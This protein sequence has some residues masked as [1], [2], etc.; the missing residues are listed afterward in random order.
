M[1]TIKKWRVICCIL[2]VFAM[3]GF[4]FSCDSGE[5]DDVNPNNQDNPQ[6]PSSTGDS[7]ITVEDPDS[8]GESTLPD[9]TKN[10]PFAR[11]SYI[12][13]DGWIA[14]FFNND[15]TCTQK[16]AVGSTNGSHSLHQWQKDLAVSY[17]YIPTTQDLSLKLK[18][19]YYGDTLITSADDAVT[20]ELRATK[21]RAAYAGYTTV[22][23]PE[24]WISAQRK[25]YEDRLANSAITYSC[26]IQN[27][28]LIL[29]DSKANEGKYK[30]EKDNTK[31][32]FEHFTNGQY[33]ISVK[34]NSG[35]LNEPVITSIGNG[36]FTGSDYKW[37]YSGTTA[38][39][40]KLGDFAGTYE[41][42]YGSCYLKLT[43]VTGDISV[44]I[45]DMVGKEY[46]LPPR[47]D[48]ET[49]TT[50]RPITKTINYTVIGGDGRTAIKKAQAYLTD[51]SVTTWEINT[52]KVLTS[53]YLDGIY[54]NAECTRSVI[55]KEILDG[56][57]VYVKL[58]A[59][60]SADTYNAAVGNIS[61]D[62]DAEVVVI[63]G[64]SNLVENPI[65]LEAIESGTITIRNPLTLSIIYVKN[66]KSKAT[67]TSPLFFI[68]V[69]A[70]DKISLYGD[71]EQYAADYGS[72]YTNISCDGDCYLYGNIMS[73]ICSTEAVT[74]FPEE[75]DHGYYRP[76][77]IFRSLFSDNTRIKNHPGKALSLPATKLGS[78]C[79]DHMFSGCTG[80]T[81]A[82]DLPATTL[83]YGC[84]D[85]MFSG[86]TNL[87]SAPVLPATTL[88]YGCYE[89]MFSG[90][91]SLTAAPV[92]PATTLESSC[93][94]FMFS[95][96]T[97]LTAAPVLPA[98][99]LESS[100][101]Y[102]MFSGCSNLLYIKCLA[103]E[104]FSSNTWNWVDS[105][106]YTGIFVTDNPDAWERGSNG[107]PSNWTVVSSDTDT[108]KDGTINAD[109][110]PCI[111]IHA[112]AKTDLIVIYRNGKYTANLMLRTTLAKDT[113]ISFTDL[114]VEKGK[115]YIYEYRAWNTD[116]DSLLYESSPIGLLV[117]TAGE[118]EL[119]LTV[120]VSAGRTTYNSENGVLTIDEQ[121]TI[122]AQL[123]ST[124]WNLE[125]H[126]E[127]IQWFRFTRTFYQTITPDTKSIVLGSDRIDEEYREELK[128]KTADLGWY[129]SV[130]ASRSAE[131]NG[132]AYDIYY[133]S[134]RGYEHYYYGEKYG[135]PNSVVI[136]SGE[137]DTSQ[138]GGS[139]TP[140]LT[141]T[142]EPSN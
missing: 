23:I 54:S 18:G 22:E 53:G 51:A 103:S 26:A 79:Y 62:P 7:T 126:L 80:L 27:D 6:N 121:P 70:G 78:H 110:V 56:V 74:E 66:G 102:N 120:S 76:E 36:T 88:A 75:Y 89:Y 64:N 63:D 139:S 140:V 106:A 49:T 128:G 2:A 25:I 99:T 105:V 65:T 33:S 60:V 100:C 130:I 142:P 37:S 118:G 131:S 137:S 77:Y 96:C 57:Q 17:T 30:Y 44:Y 4:F 47:T 10:A 11:Q 55:G 91:T 20:C 61:D 90:C 117:P 122:T 132:I 13:D 116:E 43:S 38:T 35:E 8:Y 135:L 104:V 28:C 71:N 141:P 46:E 113:D 40:V 83:E 52:L 82:P 45:K 1:E 16:H 111:T 31:I 58:N 81:S 39:L 123:N 41:F 136:P 19:V 32:K 114:N 108:T 127:L 85:S 12:S 109:G 9:L 87:T 67:T 129:V 48:G 50:Y 29:E 95:G 124:G 112:P 94:S 59:N 15:G 73:L 133:D 68:P 115:P 42:E 101:Y 125:K 97:S 93:Y 107:I 14:I 72:K 86:C 21:R 5:N 119:K 84:Y 138:G 134:D 34:N 69:N 98:T 24:D 3:I 92:L